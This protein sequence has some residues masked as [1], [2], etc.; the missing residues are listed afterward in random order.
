M[1]IDIARSAARLRRSR[2]HLALDAS[3]A[4]REPD[5]ELARSNILSGIVELVEE[6]GGQVLTS[7][8]REPET[9]GLMYGEFL[10]HGESPTFLFRRL[11]RAHD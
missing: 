8:V 1:N 10:G 7:W 4:Y 5:R 3:Q 9:P 2:R 6:I 11:R